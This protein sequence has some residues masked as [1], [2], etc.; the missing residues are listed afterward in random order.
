MTDFSLLKELQ[1]NRKR[2][3]QSLRCPIWNFRMKTVPLSQQKT[4]GLCVLP[5]GS[6]RTCKLFKGK[7]LNCNFICGNPIDFTVIEK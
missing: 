6:Q 5:G 7:G 4:P 2:E 3:M 1:K